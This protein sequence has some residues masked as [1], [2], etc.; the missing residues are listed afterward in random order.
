MRLCVWNTN[1]D[2][3]RNAVLQVKRILDMA[4]V[5]KL[6]GS[7]YVSAI[8]SLSKI[9]ESFDCTKPKFCARRIVNWFRRQ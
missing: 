7:E 6:S 9:E 8:I 4:N 1:C 3:H 2:K 5:R